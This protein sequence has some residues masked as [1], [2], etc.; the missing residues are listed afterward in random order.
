MIDEFFGLGVAV[1]IDVVTTKVARKHRWVRVLQICIG[2]LFFVLIAG[3][4]YLTVR[5]S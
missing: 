5:Y 2:L 4:I 1:A 3:L